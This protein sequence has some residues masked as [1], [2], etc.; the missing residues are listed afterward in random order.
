MSKTVPA[1]SALAQP[2]DA[3][4]GTGAAVRALRV[5]TLHGQP[6]SAPEVARR[7]RIELTNARNTLGRL[8]AL[9]ILVQHGSGRA[10][11]YALAQDHPLS[12]ALRDL[13]TA[14]S[15]RRAAI[16]RGIRE[17]AA[18]Q[19]PPP[20]AL[21]IYGSVARARDDEAS[22]LDVAFVAAPDA[23]EKQ[24]DEFRR[25]LEP[26]AEQWAVSPS[27]IALRPS[28]VRRL[29]KANSPFW[30]NLARDALPLIGLPPTEVGQSS[31]RRLTH[32]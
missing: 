27:V 26:L 9:G 12:G 31:A 4:I 24:I 17:A 3:V 21:W 13:F 30:R 15:E 19:R 16:I 32:A 23:P 18:T 8:T 22:D 29:R 1:A 7:G 5:I 25:A 10:I 20:V 2:L 6:L 28:D 11:L 14:E